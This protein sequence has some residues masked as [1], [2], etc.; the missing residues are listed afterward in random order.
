MFCHIYDNFF[1][2]HIWSRLPYLGVI[3]QKNGDVKNVPKNE[4]NPKL[5]KK[6]LELLYISIFSSETRS[7]ASVT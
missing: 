4:R 5:E 1:C 2:T 6:Y 7:N 3:L